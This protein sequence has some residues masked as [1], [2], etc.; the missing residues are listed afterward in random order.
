MA[1][2]P[3]T[4]PS[5]KPSTGVPAGADLNA[6]TQGQVEDIKALNKEAYWWL[7]NR[8]ERLE[9]IRQAGQKGV[10]RSLEQDMEA[11]RS[12]LSMVTKVFRLGL[13]SAYNSTVDEFKSIKEASGLVGPKLSH[14]PQ[15]GPPIS[16]VHD[17]LLLRWAPLRFLNITNTLRSGSKGLE[18]Y[19]DELVKKIYYKVIAYYCD[20]MVWDSKRLGR[21][22][23]NLG[24]NPPMEV[25]RGTLKRLKTDIELLTHS[26]HTLYFQVSTKEHE[27]IFAFTPQEAIRDLYLQS[28]L[29]NGFEQFV[30]RYCL[31]LMEAC[32]SDRVLSEIQRMFRPLLKKAEHVSLDFYFSLSNDPQKAR[33]RDL[34]L[35]F[36]KKIETANDNSG[37]ARHH[38][39]L[40]NAFSFS[41]VK[42]P[43]PKQRQ[44]WQT[45]IRRNVFERGLGN[46]Q[47]AN[48]LAELITL[49]MACTED[50]A[51]VRDDFANTLLTHAKTQETK[52]TAALHARHAAAKKEIAKKREEETP[53]DE[54]E[55]YRRAETKKLASMSHTLKHVA[56][57]LKTRSQRM[58]QSAAQLKGPLKIRSAKAFFA[59]ARQC[60]KEPQKVSLMLV[61]HLKELLN[62]SSRP[63][64]YTL[65]YQHLFEIV[66][67]IPLEQCMEMKQLISN[68]LGISMGPISKEEQTILNEKQQVALQEIE[69]KY[70]GIMQIHLAPARMQQIPKIPILGILKLRLDPQS[71]RKLLS[72]PVVWEAKTTS[73]P[74]D[75]IGQLVELNNLEYPPPKHD[76]LFQNITRTTPPLRCINFQELNSLITTE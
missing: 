31:T 21:L 30:F 4:A 41:R 46:P 25:V 3:I 24:E 39:G 23:S 57:N 22:V 61:K 76:I 12:A 40:V 52:M 75:A 66:E 68:K 7:G 48:L 38:Q 36:A 55:A 43:S 28:W 70:P 27:D 47:S 58:Q 67:D 15:V 50:T 49:E 73:L 53:M 13:V 34:F 54:I 72:C 26:H 9:T 65:L 59:M 29:I 16:D 14:S 33:L 42:E 10:K 44:N 37:A 8:M 17:A 19:S 64:S 5:Q 51:G 74:E 62:R 20:P 35:A 71:L 1:P 69:Y 18:F 11:T 60:A 32:E 45:Y 56:N 2:L 6:Q 63:D